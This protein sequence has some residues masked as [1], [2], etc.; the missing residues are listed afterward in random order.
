MECGMPMALESSRRCRAGCNET[1][2]RG[3]KTTKNDA[4][5]QKLVSQGRPQGRIRVG[6]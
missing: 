1:M 4:Q 6:L 5:G 2:E 3:T